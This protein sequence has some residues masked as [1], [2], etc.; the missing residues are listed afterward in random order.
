MFFCDEFI[1]AFGFYLWS[2]DC[3]VNMFVKQVPLSAKR[4]VSVVETAVRE[5]AKR[6]VVLSVN[7]IGDDRMRTLNRQYR[8]KDKTTDVLSFSNTEGEQFFQGL[9][10]TEEWGDI[11]IS[12]PQIKRQAREYEVT[13]Q[14]EFS[15][16]LVHGVLH[17]AGYDHMKKADE[18][19]MM[20][21][22]EKI[23]KKLN[24]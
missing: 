6:S 24:R 23:L 19:V 2:M 11:F 16:M 20:G 12:L 18:V 13:I 8:G 15:R 21:L 17:L 10:S 14:E 7:V 3:T 5:V 4:I 9:P 1:F 22:Q